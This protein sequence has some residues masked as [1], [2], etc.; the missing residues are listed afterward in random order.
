MAG[1]RN[2]FPTTLSIVVQLCLTLQPHEL[3]DSV[4]GFPVLYRPSEFAQIHIY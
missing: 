2:T 3:Q 1:K 4:T